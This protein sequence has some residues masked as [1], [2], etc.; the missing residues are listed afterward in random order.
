MRHSSPMDINTPRKLQ[1]FSVLLYYY[2]YYS[3]GTPVD[4]LIIRKVFNQSENSHLPGTI[5]SSMKG[6]TEHLPDCLACHLWRHTAVQ[7][8][9][10]LFSAFNMMCRLGAPPQVRSS[11]LANATC[12]R[13]SFHKA[14]NSTRALLQIII[15]K[16]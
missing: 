2:C 13:V 14:R 3:T 4:C 7:S 9:E 1:R 12:W 11:L 15:R 16:F 8:R 5:V 10:L 6:A